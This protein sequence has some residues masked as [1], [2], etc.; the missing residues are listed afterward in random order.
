MA[1]RRVCGEIGSIYCVDGHL[2][3]ELALQ[4]FVLTSLPLNVISLTG[5]IRADI[6]LQPCAFVYLCQ[7]VT[8]QPGMPHLPQVDRLPQFKT[9]YV[10]WM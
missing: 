10:D 9:Y 3:L 5:N 1:F 2:L 4:D 7:A 8:N 6:T